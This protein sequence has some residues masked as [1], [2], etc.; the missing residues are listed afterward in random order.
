[1]AQKPF[2]FRKPIGTAYAGAMRTIE[3]EAEWSKGVYGMLLV[4]R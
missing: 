3:P 2:I 4:G 1:V